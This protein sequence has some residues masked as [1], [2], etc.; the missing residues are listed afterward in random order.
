MKGPGTLFMHIKLSKIIYA[1]NMHALLAC[2]IRFAHVCLL[3]NSAVALLSLLMFPAIEDF[4]L[5]LPLKKTE[6]SLFLILSL[7]PHN[8][9][10]M[11]CLMAL[12]QVQNIWRLFKLTVS[13]DLEDVRGGFLEHVLQL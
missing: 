12:N 9:Q 8:F 4:S 7:S 10:L 13:I 3:T 11:S 1:H 6:I 5:V 2:T